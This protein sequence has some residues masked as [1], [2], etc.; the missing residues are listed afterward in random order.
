MN[1]ANISSHFTKDISYTT[2]R[3]MQ[4][5]LPHVGSGFYRTIIAYDMKILWSWDKTVIPHEMVLVPEFHKTASQPN[6]AETTK[7]HFPV[8]CQT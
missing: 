1:S 3:R 2:D 5:V 8:L 4:P 6:Y 7:W